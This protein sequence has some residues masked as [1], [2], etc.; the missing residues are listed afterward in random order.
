RRQAWLG[1]ASVIVVRGALWRKV[2]QLPLVDVEYVQ[3]K[4]GLFGQAVDCG[5]VIVHGVGGVRLVLANVAHPK[6]VQRA[7][8]RA[9]KVVP[10]RGYEREMAA[11][12]NRLPAAA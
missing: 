7:I 11:S 9:M 1:E 6:A 3:V 4:P 12:P 5:S 2:L 8:Q 10:Q